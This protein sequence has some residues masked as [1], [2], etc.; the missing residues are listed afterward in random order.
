MKKNVQGENKINLKL[1]IV[2]DS[3]VGKTSIIN[4]FLNNIFENNTSIA[5]I[6][7][8]YSKK[9]ITINDTIYNINSWDIPGQDR[10]PIVTRPF[11]NGCNGIIL[12]CEVKN[13]NSRLSLNQW[14]ESLESIEDIENIPKIIIENKSDLIENDI[15]F[16][17][18]INLL[19]ER[20][21]QLG[22]LNFFIASAKS[23]SNINDAMYFI[24]N[25]MIKNNKEENVQIYN[26]IKLRKNNN[27]DAHRCC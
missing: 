15:D 12:C 10:N 7:P 25:E 4:R 22:C 13:E 1:I 21:K 27:S 23:G 20:S 5:T 11:V 3:G 6:A 18:N 2:G 24:I 19:K 16:N 9:V 17:N 14:K 8:I 26:Q